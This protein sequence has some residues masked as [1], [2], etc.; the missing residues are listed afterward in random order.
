MT[1]FVQNVTTTIAAEASVSGAIPLSEFS[2]GSFLLPAEVTGTGWSFEASYDGSNFVAPKD[3]AGDALAEIT[4]GA[5]DAVALPAALFSYRWARI[6]SNGSEESER[7]I[8][9]HLSGD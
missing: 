9:V 5:N 2:R 6:K 3:S 1:S 7:T 4:A 8:K